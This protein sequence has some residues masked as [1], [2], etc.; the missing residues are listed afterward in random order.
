MIQLK[1]CLNQIHPLLITVLYP[2]PILLFF[3]GSESNFKPNHEIF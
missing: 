2:Y 3:F 1:F